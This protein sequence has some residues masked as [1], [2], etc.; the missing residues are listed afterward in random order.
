MPDS[1][2]VHHEAAAAVCDLL[3]ALIEHGGWLSTAEL[4]ERTGV[5]RDT[6]RRVLRELSSRGWVRPETHAGAE[7]WTIGPELP[8]I[9]HAYAALLA[10]R[11]AALRA[12]LDRVVAPFG[13]ITPP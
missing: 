12:E 4:S 1:R 7:V 3:A 10:A 13:G 2:V 6:A 11:L 9:G 5:G 8:R